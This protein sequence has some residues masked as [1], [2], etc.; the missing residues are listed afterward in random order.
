MNHGGGGGN[1]PFSLSSLGA[2]RLVEIA[3]LRS[4]KQNINWAE[5]RELIGMCLGLFLNEAPVLA[6]AVLSL[7]LQVSS[8]FSLPP[9]DL[10]P[11]SA[12]FYSPP[13]SKHAPPGPAVPPMIV[14]QQTSH[15]S[16]IS[17]HVQGYHTVHGRNIGSQKWRLDHS[18]LRYATCSYVPQN[19]Y[20]YVA[21][22]LVIRASE[23]AW[24]SGHVIGYGMY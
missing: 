7:G 13:G 9:P 10:L 21:M 3:G 17:L 18:V 15:K 19:M 5:T 20:R 8:P 1:S 23:Y 6:S 12:S 22:C 11:P 24:I 2:P 4:A 14:S 16:P